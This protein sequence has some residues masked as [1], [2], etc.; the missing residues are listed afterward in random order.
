MLSEGNWFLSLAV[1]AD[2]LAQKLSDND[3]IRQAMA[4]AIAGLGDTIGIQRH[5]Q[6]E[7]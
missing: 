3:V 5:D 2:S 1:S 6:R 7:A 4:A